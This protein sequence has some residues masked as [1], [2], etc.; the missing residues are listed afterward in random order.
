M[1]TGRDEFDKWL[2]LMGV[3][4]YTDRGV[5][6]TCGEISELL[7][8]MRDRLLKQFLCGHS[9]EAHSERERKGF[10]DM[11]EQDLSA[12]PFIQGDC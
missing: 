1:P 12:G 5:L 10:D 9:G 6:R 4:F 7:V 2:A 8:R 3:Y 11:G